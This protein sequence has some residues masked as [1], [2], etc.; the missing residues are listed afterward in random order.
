MKI[1]KIFSKSE[2]NSENNKSKLNAPFIGRQLSRFK[3]GMSYLTLAMS[4]I[5]AVMTTKFA[6]DSISIW[7]ILAVLVPVAFVGTILLGY[8]LDKLDISTQDQRKSNEMTHRFLLTSDI[9]NQEFQLLQTKMLLKALQN[10]KENRDI[11]INEIM[12]D[13][14]H[15]LEKWKSPEQK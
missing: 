8:F 2:K 12:Q 5:T 7:I 4:S 11:N 6:Y 13:Y 1:A 15:Y 9:K 10:I 14:E 3:L